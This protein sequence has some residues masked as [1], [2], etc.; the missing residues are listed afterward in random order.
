[1]KQILLTILFLPM[2][3]LAFAQHK[4]TVEGN[5]ESIRNTN[6]IYL[7]YQKNGES[8]LDSA[9]IRQ[10]KFIFNGTITDPIPV[11]LYI[12]ENGAMDSSKSNLQVNLISF[13]LEPGK[14]KLMDSSGKIIVS[15]GPINTDNEKLKVLLDATSER[16]K[17]IQEEMTH[18]EGDKKNKDFSLWEKLA[19]SAEVN[20]ELRSIKRS[21]IKEN[22]ESYLSL[23]LLEESIGYTDLLEI[24]R[25]Y[26]NLSPELKT[27]ALWKARNE[28]ITENIVILEKTAIGKMS[29]DFE[30]KDAYGRSVKL[31]DFRGKYVLL[32]FWASWCGPCRA[33]NPKVLAAYQKYKDKGFTV[34]GVSADKD[35]QAWLE[36]IASDKLPWAQVWD[37][38]GRRNPIIIQYG[39]KGIPS[40]FLIDPNGIIIDKELRGDKL[41]KRLAEIFQQ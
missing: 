20:S 11:L 21:F 12:M 6:K 27:T 36:A 7:N 34:L 37:P 17:K 18:K 2:L 38:S 31:S 29:M 10:G 35:K 41:E 39:V 30:Q 1:M 3:M 28:S 40:S 15:G 19:A 22:P 5:I 16:Q 33:E 4:F 24:K 14:I 25:E 8:V 13:Y 26:D 9:L 23:L 32:D